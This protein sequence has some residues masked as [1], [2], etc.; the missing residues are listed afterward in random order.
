MVSFDVNSLFTNIPLDE[1]IDI[2]VNLILERKPHLNI[3]SDELRQLFLFATSKT[4]FLFKGKFYDQIDGVAMGSPLGPTLA[5]LFMGVHEKVWIEKYTQKGP[6]YYKRYVDDIFAVFDC[7]DEALQFFEYLNTRHPN[8]TFSIECENNRT[9]PFLDVNIS[10]KS[11]SLVTSVYH[12]TTYT[13]LLM[14]FFSFVPHCYKNG[15]IR[16]LVDRTF[17]I[18]NSLD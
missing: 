13:G 12:K 5:N 4:C 14:N 7:K 18:N 15:L 6:S 16:T 10:C 17:K 3:T 2:A 8:I 9:L 1:T 11:D